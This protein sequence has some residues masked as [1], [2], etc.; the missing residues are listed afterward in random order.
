MRGSEEQTGAMFSYL[1]PDALA[2]ANH[3]LRSIRPLVNAALERL[4]PEFYRLYA[5]GGRWRKP[6]YGV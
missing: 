4:S 6:R 3:P 5:P 1:S 2:P